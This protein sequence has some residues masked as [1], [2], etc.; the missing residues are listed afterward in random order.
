VITG[1][2]A[3]KAEQKEYEIAFELIKLLLS[4]LSI[5]NMRQVAIIPGDHDWHNSSVKNAN[6][7]KIN[8]NTDFELNKVK[9]KNFND[10]LY[11]KIKNSDFDN[12]KII[13]DTTPIGEKILLLSLNS[14]LN[15]AKIEDKGDFNIDKLRTELEEIINNNPHKNLLMAFHH[16]ISGSYENKTTGS[17]AQGSWGNLLSLLNEKNIKCIFYGNEHTHCT[18]KIG[19][20]DIYISDAGTLSGITQPMGSF[21]CYEIIETDNKITLNNYIGLLDKTDAIGETGFGNWNI[22][23]VKSND[24]EQINEFVIFNNEGKIDAETEIKEIPFVEADNS[25]EATETEPHGLLI[26]HY[27]Y[28]NKALSNDLYEIVK[29]KKLFHTGHF[30]WTEKSRSL[31]WIDTLKLLENYEDLLFAKNAIIDVLNELRVQYN[32]QQQSNLDYDLIIGLGSVGTMIATK[33]ALQ[34]GISF[35]SLPYSYRKEYNKFETKLD[36]D[37][38]KVYKNIVIV[39]DV[40]HDGDSI[41]EIVDNQQKD[42]FTNVENVF[43]VSLFCTGTNLPD[44]E[45]IHFLNVLQ[46]KIAECPH[47]DNPKYNDPK[48]KNHCRVFNDNLSEVHCFYNAIKSK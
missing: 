37:E 38:N 17:I 42:F 13:F 26:D 20:T 43:V 41:V 7:E 6:R 5:S 10:Y 12:S 33:A 19:T 29:K 8:N 40:V 3:D 48:D 25:H 11:K 1:D 24:T 47:K 36:I 46:L 30:H 32:S 28:V 34:L 31:N 9:Y 23:N 2:I 21:K 4:E 14:T 18:K 15:I 39:S 22:N 16:N 44:R 27:K 35:S 45:N